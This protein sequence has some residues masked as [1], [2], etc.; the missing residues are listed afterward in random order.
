MNKKRMYQFITLFML[1][2]GSILLTKVQTNAWEIGDNGVAYTTYTVSSN[3]NGLILT[4]EAYLVNN[5]I[6]KVR[7]KGTNEYHTLT[8]PQEL[9]YEDLSGYLYVVEA[10]KNDVKPAILKIKG[11]FSELEYI[12]FDYLNTPQGVYVT[13]NNTTDPTDDL[14][15]VADYG[16]QKV[17]IYDANNNIV[18]EFGKP[19]HPLYGE[20]VIFKPSKIVVDHVGTM[21]IVDASNGNG[22]V[23]LTSDGEFL[24]Y[25]GANYTNPSLSYIIRFMF[26]SKEQKQK[27]YRK[28]IVPTNMA[29]DNDGL[30]NTVTKNGGD[31]SLKRL[32]IAGDNLLNPQNNYVSESFADVSVGPI[33]N[34]YTV[35]SDGWIYEYDVNGDLLFVFGGKNSLSSEYI[36]LFNNPISIEVDNNYNLYIID[37]N[38]I[39]TFKPTEFCNYV[40]TAINLYQNG[41]YASSRE[42]WEKVLQLNNMFDLAH[43]GIAKAYLIEEDYD[44]ALYH[45]ELAKDVSGYSEA[46]WELRNA[47]LM[48]YMGYVVV[49]IV[50]L[51]IIYYILKFLESKHILISLGY[52]KNFF[53]FIKEKLIKIKFFK[54]LGYLFKMLKHPLDCFYEIK[55]HKAISTF[56][57]IILYLILFGEL[58]LSN[59]FTG[60]IFNQTDVEEISLFGIFVSSIA[61][62][63][64][65]VICHYLISSIVQGNGRLKDV[66]ISTIASFAP[67]IIFLPIIIIVSRFLTLNES[68]IYSFGTIAIWAWS[69]ILLFFMIKEIQELEFGE[70]IANILLTAV[71]MILFVAFGFLLYALASQIINFIKEFIMEVISNG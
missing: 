30:I 71:T 38:K 46:Y 40:H 55:H 45:F 67:V 29:I 68:F 52:V 34:I 59:I 21:Y 15:Y 63:L 10:G 49:G 32:N 27:L 26:S 5:V 58:I 1:I 61:I 43:R 65:F 57:A 64:L 70:T 9:Y 2:V 17:V 37:N 18:N 62:I 7:I 3:K 42:P 69:F 56:T 24:G 25:F 19:T 41:L 4:Q 48:N 16:L 60:F 54:E 51:I 6:S 33:N 66:F 20:S 22:L 11:D 35:S 39:T 53:R 47:V 28:P 36:G 50:I 44:N 13:N 12:G 14:I 31:Y 8:N 23:Q